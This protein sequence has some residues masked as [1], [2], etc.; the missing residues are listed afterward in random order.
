MSFEI[1][2]GLFGFDF[3]DYHAVIGASLDADVKAIRKQY[4]KIARRLHPD[5]CRLE[6]KQLAQTLLSKLI[7]PAYAKLSNDKD[8]AD[9]GVLLRMTG[10]RLVEDRAEPTLESEAA[11]ALLKLDSLDSVRKEYAK[12]VTELGGNHYEDLSESLARIGALSELN[13]VYLLRRTQS[14]TG[15]GLPTQQKSTKVTP[16]GKPAPPPPPPPPKSRKESFVASYYKRAESLLERGSFAS[17]RKEL[18]DAIKLDANSAE[19]HALMAKV[20]L[21][22]NEKSPASVNTTM[23]RSHL[24]KAVKAD[25]QAPIVVEVRKLFNKSVARPGANKPV[26]KKPTGKKPEKGGGGLFGGLFGKK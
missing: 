14:D 16:S 19:C 7:N 24:S 25:P 20:Y 11:Q 15:W 8:Y 26:S 6:N 4:L 2:R 23:A 22:Q 17:A 3:T 1:G 5:V 12:A 18:Q 10:K 9:Y 21:L 13:Q